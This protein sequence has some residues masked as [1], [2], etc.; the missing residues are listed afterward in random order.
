MSKF[1]NSKSN[2][3]L[4]I[5]GFILKGKLTELPG[6]KFFPV[7]EIWLLM[8]SIFEEKSYTISKRGVIKEDNKP[9]ATKPSS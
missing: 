2:K 7:D 3:A 4:F 9:I 1:T 8:K 5:D 6:P